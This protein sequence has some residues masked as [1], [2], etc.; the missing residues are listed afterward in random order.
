MAP[1]ICSAVNVLRLTLAACGG[2]EC[3][4]VCRG[5]LAG[6][7]LREARAILVTEAL[8]GGT[9]RT[10][11]TGVAWISTRESLAGTCRAVHARAILAAEEAMLGYSGSSRP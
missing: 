5:L 4:D 10:G 3:P 7:Q 6:R 9:I 11:R 8:N 2:D 1:L